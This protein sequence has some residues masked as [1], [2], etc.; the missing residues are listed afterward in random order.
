MSQTVTL[1]ISD[2]EFERLNVIAHLRDIPIA[3]LLSHSMLGIFPI[4]DYPDDDQIILEIMRWYNLDQLTQAV[5]QRIPVDED[6]RID[7]L[8]AQS[9]E[10]ELTDDENEILESL[11][12]KWGKWTIIHAIALSVLKERGYDV[13]R[14]SYSRSR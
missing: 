10:R 1:D 9:K 3:E 4:E 8:I 6:A 7:K 5:N 2:A 13:S 12:D 14:Y 11:M